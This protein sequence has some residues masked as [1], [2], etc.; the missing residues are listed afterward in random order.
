MLIESVWVWLNVCWFI[1][2][3]SVVSVFLLIRSRN[4][5][6]FVGLCLILILRVLRRYVLFM[7]RLLMKFLIADSWLQSC[8]LVLLVELFF[9]V[10]SFFCCFESLDSFVCCWP[11]VLAFFVRRCL[12]CFESLDSLVLA[13]L[14]TMFRL[15]PALLGCLLALFWIVRFFGVGF[16]V[17]SSWCCFESLDSFGAS[18]FVDDVSSVSSFAGLSVGVVLNR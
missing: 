12:C 11:L 4:V 7:W 13:C 1:V 17:L 18:L 16:A 14:L 10:F 5:M 8:A 2:W 9:S 6:E 15:F 3:G